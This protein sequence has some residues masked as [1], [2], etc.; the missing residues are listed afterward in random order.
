M[1]MLSGEIEPNQRRSLFH[2]R[3]TCEDKCFD[4]IIDGGSTD[5]LVSKKMVI[6][7]NLKRQKQ[8]CPYRIAWVQDDHKVMFNEQ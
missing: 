5:N 7:L 6:K 1:V 8:P 4:V 2:T 3:C